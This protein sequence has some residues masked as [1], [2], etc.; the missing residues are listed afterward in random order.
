[1]P[2]INERIHIPESEI[3]WHFVSS[4]G[5]G[6]Q[7]VNKVASKAVLSWDLASSASLHEDVKARLRTQQRRRHR[8]PGALDAHFGGAIG[9]KSA[10]GKTVWRSYGRWW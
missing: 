10:T 4:S 8:R 1:M 9:I 7:N 2:E 5:P 3:T 6:G